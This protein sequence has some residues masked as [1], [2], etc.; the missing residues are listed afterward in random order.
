ME[1]HA[2]VKVVTG[3]SGLAVCLVKLVWSRSARAYWWTVSF[4]HQIYVEQGLNSNTTL[5]QQAHGRIAVSRWAAFRRFILVWLGGGLLYVGYAA[6][7]LTQGGTPPWVD[8]AVISGWAILSGYWLDPLAEWIE[9]YRILR[10]GTMTTLV[11]VFICGLLYALGLPMGFGMWRWDGEGRLWLDSRDVSPGSVLSTILASSIVINNLSAS[12]VQIYVR[13]EA[14]WITHLQVIV[15]ASLIGLGLSVLA[16]S[17]RLFWRTLFKSGLVLRRAIRRI[18]ALVRSG[19]V[20][21]LLRRAVIVVFLLVLVL[22]IVGLLLTRPVGT[23]EWTPVVTAGLPSGLLPS[24]D[25]LVADTETKSILAGTQRGVFRSTDNGESWQLTSDALPPTS[26]TTFAVQALAVGTDGSIFASTNGTVVLSSDGGRTWKSFA[27]GL[28]GPD[29]WVLM[30]T[31]GGEIFAGTRDGGVYHLENRSQVWEPA[32]HGLGNQHVMALVAD[33]D[34]V[35]FAGTYGAGIFLSDN[36][37]QTWQQI[38]EHLPDP[39]VIS[40]AIGTDRTSIFAG[41]LSGVYISRDRGQSWYRSSYG[42]ANWIVAALIVEPDSR[43]LF[44]ATWGGVFQFD[45]VG[46]SWL[47]VDGNLARWGVRTL[48]LGFDNKTLFAGTRRGGIFRSSDGGQSWASVNQGLID[49]DTR[50]LITVPYSQSLLV[51]TSGGI[52]Y[53]EDGGYSWSPANQG[54]SDQEDVQ[55]LARGFKKDVYALTTK[56]LFL[57]ADRGMTWQQVGQTIPILSET[58]I[59]LPDGTILVGGVGAIAR[60]T[61]SGMTWQQAATELGTQ[62]VRTL[63]AATD[64]QRVLAGTA[65]GILQ[66]S[67]AGKT[68]VL[69]GEGLRGY[70][71]KTLFLGQRREVLA[72]TTRGVFR[73]LDDGWTW[74]SANRGLT[75]LDVETLTAGSVEQSLLAGMHNGEIFRSTDWGE[76]WHDVWSGSTRGAVRDLIVGPDG[77]SLFMGNQSG[78]FHSG[79]EGESWHLANRGLSALALD[80][81]VIGTNGKTLYALTDGGSLLHEGE[82]DV[83]YSRDGGQ[84]WQLSALSSLPTFSLDPTWQRPQMETTNGHISLARPGMGWLQWAEYRFSP[85]EAILVTGK[86]ATLYAL[87]GSTMILRAELPL[88]LI[89]R[90]PTPYLSMVVFTRIGLDWIGSNALPILLVLSSA[91]VI[92]SAYLYLGVVRPAHLRFSTTVWLLRNPRHLL[93]AT[94][95]QSYEYR[96]AMNDALERLILLTI[97]VGTA[98]SESMLEEKLHQTG[99]KVTEERL[100]F[101][102]ANLRYRSLLVQADSKWRL[103]E[104]LLAQLQRREVGKRTLADLTEEINSELPIRANTLRFLEHSGFVAT[105]ISGSPAIRCVPT[106]SDMQR[107]L[108]GVVYAWP[109]GRTLDGNNVLLI[110]EEIR[111][112]DHEA[113]LVFVVTDQRPTD[114]AWAQIGTLRMERFFVL[115]LES[116]LLQEAMVSGHERLLLRQEIE[117]RMGVHFDP[118]DVRDP[119][120]GAFSFFGRNALVESLLRRLGAGRPVGIFGLRKMGKSSLLQALRDRAAFPVAA[121]NLQTVHSETLEELYRRILRYWAHRVQVQYGLEWEPPVIARENSTG[122]FTTAALELLGR[123]EVR[124]AGCARLG[125]FLDEVELITPL[126]TASSADLA[127]YLTLLRALRGLVDEDGRLSL[128]VASLNPSI[129]RINAWGNE[130]NPAFNLFQEIYLPPL[131]REDCIQM[132]CN[133]GGQVGLAYSE[134]A[135]T[136]TYELSG[137]HPFLARQLCSVLYRQREM[138]EGLIEAADLSAAIEQFIYDEQTSVHLDAGIWQDAGNPA[139]WGT[140]APSVNQALLLDIARGGGPVLQAELLQ[141]PDADMR[142]AA[143]FNLE[144]FHFIYQPEPRVYALRFGLLRT[145]LRR[146]KLGLE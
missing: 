102:L 118:Y 77:S 120:S 76:T 14:T 24:I 131:M 31:P 17:W 35:L 139:L 119:V 101:A 85:P 116:V 82:G 108:P 103:S 2:T 89:W 92:T 38:S 97:P 80:G 62:Q 26:T 136:S 114:Q 45:D 20:W 70:D 113:S 129:N 96:C 84:T 117:K 124:G 133:I 111:Q 134:E 83:F 42:L 67:D 8:I 37:G 25:T 11:I 23:I 49:I 81:F 55:A 106:F 19:I 22:D 28:E 60:S 121:V 59:V 41:T 58:L 5:R 122:V 71:V 10:Y 110:R 40:L 33:Q 141:G 99:V 63:I 6:L 144:R 104:P 21:L 30:K 64:G 128:L 32:N 44:A 1:A 142:L 46:D 51:A 98:C 91:V 115:P 52:F 29:V 127:H 57:S 13:G 47:S 66:S 74:Q 56:G 88:P 54:L 7:A 36:D 105:Q 86:Q 125:L 27:Q 93:A 68:W 15:L 61:D 65:V 69:F 94:S 90:A 123:L 34:G 39:F 75:T 18:G 43:S 109:L 107:N 9:R 126:P 53:S 72:G 50:A 79:D 78:V 140:E 48:A 112:V 100:L 130:Q 87:L 73:S 3:A 135:A 137:G 12:F 146:R 138:R 4:E 16:L 132:I 95:Y 143:L 145:W